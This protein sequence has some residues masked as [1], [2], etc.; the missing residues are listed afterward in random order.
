ML[1]NS[2][3]IAEKLRAFYGREATVI[4]PPFES[5]IFSYDSA[6][7]KDTYFLA[8]G[9]MIHYKKFPLVVETFKRLGLPLKVVGSGPDE[10]AVKRA[11]KGAQNIEILPF[12][13]TDQLV[14]VIRRAQATVVPQLEDF[15]LTTVESIACG[16]PVVGYNQ[17]GTAEIVEEGLNGTLFS[18]QSV[19]G[20]T[21]A[22]ARFQKMSFKPQD[23]ARSA[24]QFS[25]ERFQEHFVELVASALERNYK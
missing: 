16:T 14:D 6:T 11:A 18:D 10:R 22:V 13:E 17:G 8:F 15:G 12:L 24:N 5:H 25:K 1:A 4:H 7:K 2:Y 20:L 19:E 3:H 9:R 21:E 23:V